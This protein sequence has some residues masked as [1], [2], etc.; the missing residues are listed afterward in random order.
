MGTELDENR[1]DVI[2]HRRLG[3]PESPGDG[4][5]ADPV[6]Q[7]L[8]HLLL[9]GREVDLHRCVPVS[10]RCPLSLRI[11]QMS[12]PWALRTTI[13]STDTRFGP[14]AVRIVIRVEGMGH[15]SRA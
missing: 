7:Q 11:L 6:G 14:S 3:D 5:R 4:P 2:T 15:P 12:G 1:A 13:V 9:A 10:G 8:E